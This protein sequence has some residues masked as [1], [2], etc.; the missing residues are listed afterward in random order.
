MNHGRELIRSRYSALDL[1]DRINRLALDELQ[2]E[3]AL[4]NPLY[5]LEQED[6]KTLVTNQILWQITE[7]EKLV[8]FKVQQVGRGDCV[9]LVFDAPSVKDIFTFAVF[10]Q[11][12]LGEFY[13]FLGCEYL[14]SCYIS[15]LDRKCTLVTQSGNRI[16]I[17]I[18][19]DHIVGILRKLEGLCVVIVRE[20]RTKALPYMFNKQPSPYKN[21]PPLPFG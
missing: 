19:L 18:A 11:R 20:V 7:G 8:T 3:G 15:E 6:Q 4:F 14:D 17:D 2:L 13:K 10:D 1:A 5:F 9:N 16:V 12:N 21:A